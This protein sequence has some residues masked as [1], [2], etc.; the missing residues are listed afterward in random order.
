MLVLGSSHM[1]ATNVKQDENM[2][3]VYNRIQADY[4]AYNQESVDTTFIK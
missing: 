3:A 4:K 2:V 1:E